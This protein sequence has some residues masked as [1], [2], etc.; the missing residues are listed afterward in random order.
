MALGGKGFMLFAR[1]QPDTPGK[2]AAHAHSYE[3]LE[4]ASYEMLIRRAHRAGDTATAATA[5]R[6]RD[7]EEAMLQRLAGDFDLAVDASLAGQ[8][9]E[10]LES[11]LRSYLA[12]AHALEKQ[13]IALLEKAIEIAGDETLEGIYRSHLEE[14]HE[15]AQLVEERLNALGGDP[16]TLKDTVLELAGLEWGLFFQA[17]GDTPGKLAVFAFAVEHLEIAGYELL[18]RVAQRVGDQGTIDLTER[19]LGQ[20]RGMATRLTKAFDRAFEAS[21]EAQGV[22]AS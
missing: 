13:S 6:I 3:A 10:A 19:I 12:D 22:A 4:M 7:Q 9:A 20:E 8:D 14:S 17:Q 21:M 5:R 2:L 18:A 16:S 11:S 1:S 15:H